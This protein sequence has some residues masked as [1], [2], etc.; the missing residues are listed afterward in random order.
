M[1]NYLKKFIVM[2]LVLLS[3]FAFS[4][5]K[6][7]GEKKGEIK[8]DESIEISEGSQEEEEDQTLNIIAYSSF[9]DEYGAGEH[10]VYDFEDTEGIE[11]NLINGG[12]SSEM[13]S[14]IK[15]NY[16]KNKVDVVV[17]LGDEY[18]NTDIKN[19]LT[20]I[21][22]FDY[23]YYAFLI[24]SDSDITPPSSLNDLLKDEYKKKFILIDPRTS[25]VGA[26]LLYWTASAYPDTWKDWWKK[27]SENALTMA[28][29]WSEAYGLFLNGEAPLVLSYT[30][31]PLYDLLETG[32]SYAKALDFSEGHIKTSEYMAI[33]NNTKKELTARKF[34]RFMLSDHI[35]EVLSTT[36]VM[37]PIS[38]DSYKEPFELQKEPSK[39]IERVDIPLETLLDEWTKVVL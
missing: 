28:S 36:N 1:K 27:A 23:S 37:Y 12:S 3:I 11:V 24:A 19:Y 18:I 32:E 22:P 14:Y 2:L 38:K 5:K 29:S 33:V 4:C 17:G 31:S 34:L 8:T 7:D 16:D 39:V 9:A 15:S 10:V 21:R 26:G 20:T 30:T 25:V 13:I 6:G 35:Q